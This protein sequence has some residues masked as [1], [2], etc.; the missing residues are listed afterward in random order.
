[1]D[2]ITHRTIEV[3]GIHMHIAEQGTGPLVLLL[4]GFPCLWY[5]WRH[6]IPVLAN[7][8][9]HVVAPDMRGYGQTEAPADP[10]K[11][12]SLHIV[13]DVVALIEALGEKQVYLVGHD[14]GAIQAWYTALFRPDLIKCVVALSVAFSFAFR[15]PKYS[16]LDMVRAQAGDKLYIIQWQEPGKAE[17]DLGKN[18]KLWF[19][20]LYSYRTP[21]M[22][23]AN[24]EESVVDNMK[25]IDALPSWITEKDIQYY[26]DSFSKTGFTPALNWYRN[27]HKTWELC[28]PWTGKGVSVPALVMIG[29]IDLTISSMRPYLESPLFKAHVPNGEFRIFS[30]VGHF[31]QEE[32]SEIVNDCIIQYLKKF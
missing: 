5:T 18:V 28:A 20:K 23:M 25:A 11:Y 27:I 1:M 30:G 6:Q 12:T 4:H 13:G 19:E 21:Q 24:A 16:M 9:Y 15:H 31:I 8:G 22:L 2:Q 7:A 17:A 10:T 29:D 26:V 32:A 3:N 14:W